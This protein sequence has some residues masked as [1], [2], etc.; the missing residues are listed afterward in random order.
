MNRRLKETPVKLLQILP[1]E[2]MVSSENPFKTFERRARAGEA[3]LSVGRG[4]RGVRQAIWGLIVRTA[5]LV[6]RSA[7]AC[8]RGGFGVIRQVAKLARALAAGS[9]TAGKAVNQSLQ[10]I[11]TVFRSS[12]R[13]LVGLWAG[14]GDG[15]RWV[16]QRRAQIELRAQAWQEV[17]AQQAAMT[18]E[19][20][21]FRSQ[22]QTQ[23]QEL[24][25][26]TRQLVEVRAL[27]TSQQQV[28]LCL[29][30]ELDRRQELSSVELKREA[31]KSRLNRKT[32]TVSTKRKS[33]QEDHKPSLTL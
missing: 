25:R 5:S 33:S 6:H 29:G 11:G 4:I 22:L 31:R 13:S 10:T 27:A 26:L 19:L 12:W 28:L 3:L 15:R 8:G 24:A 32:S 16:R 2:S 9:R 21:R 20:T 7:C 1:P 18:E 17:H 23:D 14:W 30:K